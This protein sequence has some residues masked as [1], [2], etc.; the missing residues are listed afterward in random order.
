[1]LPAGRAGGDR[2]SKGVLV[3]RLF[4]GVGLAGAALGIGAVVLPLGVANADVVNQKRAF[5]TIARVST[6]CV[7][8]L[9][10]T[11]AQGVQLFGFTNGA[12][13]LTWQ[14]LT[15]SSQSAPTVV[16]STTARSVDHTVPPSG[17]LLFEACVVKNANAAQDFDL[18]LN[19]APVE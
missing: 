17:N 11:S 19:S 16:F 9:S 7:G 4:L 8:P 14:V 6:V 3:K 12:T 5:G 1:M 10:P 2:N 13:D 15:V 18:T